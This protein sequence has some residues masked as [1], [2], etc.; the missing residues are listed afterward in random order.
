VGR[1]YHPAMRHPRFRRGTLVRSH[2]R[3][4]ASIFHLIRFSMRASATENPVIAGTSTY[5]RPGVT[6]DK[7]SKLIKL[8][9]PFCRSVAAGLVAL[10]RGRS[11]SN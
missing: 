3:S 8:F 4:G 10:A 9:T 11:R 6:G 2:R 1:A 7:I 5:R